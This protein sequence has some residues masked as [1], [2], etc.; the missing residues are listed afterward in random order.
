[1]RMA[2]SWHFVIGLSAKGSLTG[3]FDVSR[4]QI[5]TRNKPLTQNLSVRM[6]ALDQ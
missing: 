4:A 6:L 2:T 5:R 1:M 3:F